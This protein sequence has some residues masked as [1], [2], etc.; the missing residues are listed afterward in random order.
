M[1]SSA[2]SPAEVQYSNVHSKLITLGSVY[3]RSERFFPVRYLALI[4]EQHACER[5]WGSHSVHQ[6]LKEMGVSTM[7]LFQVYDNMCRA[8]V[9]A[10]KLCETPLSLLSYLLYFSSILSISLPSLPPLPLPYS[11]PRVSLTPFLDHTPSLSSLPSQDA[12]WESHGDT[13]H[14]M[15]AM[16]SLL[17][18]YVHV[19]SDVSIYEQ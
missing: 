16:T 3:S 11:L 5:G 12:F 19:P 8:R 14:V 17:E 2:G 13:L 10:G 18:E 4:L 15:K 9:S 1:V 6:L 7:A